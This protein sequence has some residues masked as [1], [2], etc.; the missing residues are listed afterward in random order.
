MPLWVAEFDRVW[1]QFEEKTAIHLD[2]SVQTPYPTSNYSEW[3]LGTASIGSVQSS[4]GPVHNSRKNSYT[5][6]RHIGV[7]R[8]LYTIT[9][10]LSYTLIRLV[11]AS[12]RVSTYLASSSWDALGHMPQQ[13]QAR[14]Q[15][16]GAESIVVRDRD[17]GVYINAPRCSSAICIFRITRSR[18]LPSISSQGTRIYRKYNKSGFTRSRSPQ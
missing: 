6:I 12:L 13:P 8:G 2:S 11:K 15:I 9:G 10:K 5:L 3:T 4:T 7:R 1:T 17:R 16:I 18:T 14:I